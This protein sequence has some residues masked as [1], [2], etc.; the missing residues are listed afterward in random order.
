MQ[1]D[2]PFHLLECLLSA[3]FLSIDALFLKGQLECPLFHE[4]FLESRE[5]EMIGVRW[6]DSWCGAPATTLW[7]FFL[8]VTLY[9]IVKDV[10]YPDKGRDH[11]HC[12][13]GD[14]FQSNMLTEISCALVWAQYCSKNEHSS[15]L[16]STTQWTH[17][18]YE[19]WR[20][21]MVWSWGRDLKV[22][23]F[24][25]NRI[26]LFVCSFTLFC[27]NILTGFRIQMYK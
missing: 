1:L 19:E 2:I 15:G 12:I 13:C 24:P 10:L 26:F 5:L 7:S 14:K 6:T 20:V 9:H 8:H 18:D 27:V 4:A 25:E 11:W 22:G 23:R 21:G 17:S 16:F 3:L